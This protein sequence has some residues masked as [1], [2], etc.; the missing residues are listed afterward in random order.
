MDELEEIRQRKLEQLQREQ[1]E[2]AQIQ[3]QILALENFVKQ[4]FTKDA[5]AR[6]GNLKTGHPE[7]AIQ[8]LV[9]LSEAIKAGKVNVVDDEL[10]KSILKEM[11]SKKQTRII[12]K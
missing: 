6:F 12:R 3:Q 10:L 9:V 11:Q 2:Q 8:I 1:Q 5:L 4:K 7:L